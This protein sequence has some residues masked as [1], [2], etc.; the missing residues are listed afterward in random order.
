MAMFSREN[1][2]TIR[3]TDME[4]TFIKTEQGTKESGR[5]ICSTAKEKKFGPITR[6]MRVIITKERSMEK[7]FTSGR[8]AGHTLV[9]GR[10]I[11]CTEKA[12]TLGPTAE[13]IKASMKWTKSMAMEFTSGRMAAFT[14]D[15]G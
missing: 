3:L 14:K 10:I 15:T 1:G 12:F 7:D 2:S 4:C 9:S 5:T 13:D 11:T 8:T 6:C